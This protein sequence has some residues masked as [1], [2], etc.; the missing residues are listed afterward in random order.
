MCAGNGRGGRS[1]G[2]HWDRSKERRE[3]LNDATKTATSPADS[4]QPDMSNLS[5]LLK[6]APANLPA[7]SLPTRWHIGK[8]KR[9]NVCFEDAPMWPRE[10]SSTSENP[11]SKV[12]T[13]RNANRS[14]AG[15]PQHLNETQEARGKTSSQSQRSNWAPFRNAPLPSSRN[16]TRWHDAVRAFRALSAPSLCTPPIT[17]RV[18]NVSTSRSCLSTREAK[19]P[20]AFISRCQG[21]ETTAKRLATAARSLNLARSACSGRP[22]AAAAGDCGRRGGGGAFTPSS[23]VGASLLSNSNKPSVR[24]NTS[25]GIPFRIMSHL[26]RLRRCGGC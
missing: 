6:P 14:K 20:V 18:S 9:R 16:Q 19:A 3:D 26:L 13:F 1:S 2:R 10:L 24:H 8:A 12:T 11:R 25:S 5:S 21:L 4:L 17:T 23:S 22:S 15:Q 7:P